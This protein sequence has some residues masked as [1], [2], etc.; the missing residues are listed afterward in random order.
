[1]EANNAARRRR[2]IAAKLITVVGVVF[3]SLTLYGSAQV[4][5]D[6]YVPSEFVTLLGTYVSGSLPDLFEQDQKYVHV[7]RAPVECQADRWCQTPIVDIMFTGVQPASRLR[8]ETVLRSNG[9]LAGSFRLWVR[10]NSS[11]YVFIGMFNTG[12]G[13]TK[14]SVEPPG[15]PMQYIG[16]DGSMRFRIEKYRGLYLTRPCAFHYDM[17]NVFTIPR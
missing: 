11:Q 4:Q 13:D 15:D 14:F 16:Q 3:C 2:T 9:A 5:E 1:M 8:F 10:N 6:R 12:V 7:V 17:A